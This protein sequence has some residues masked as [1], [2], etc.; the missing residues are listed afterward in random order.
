[1]SFWGAMGLVV[2]FLIAQSIYSYF[3]RR[4]A[5]RQVWATYRLVIQTLRKQIAAFSNDVDSLTTIEEGKG[6]YN[7]GMLNGLRGSYEAIKALGG[8]G[9]YI[10]EVDLDLEAKEA[11]ST[12]RRKQNEK[13]DRFHGSCISICSGFNLRTNN[14]VLRLRYKHGE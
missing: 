9:K 10:K 8:F 12:E 1:M 7:L 11:E 5:M 6:M 2:L 14:T 3:Q 4:R 13:A